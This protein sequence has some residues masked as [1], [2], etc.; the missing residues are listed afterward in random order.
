MGD[1]DFAKSVIITIPNIVKK[2]DTLLYSYFGPFGK[3]A[4]KKESS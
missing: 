2:P 1:T 4:A 3:G